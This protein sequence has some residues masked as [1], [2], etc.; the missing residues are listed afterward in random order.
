MT[1]SKPYQKVVDYFQALESKIG[2][3]LVLG[4]VKHFGYY[5]SEKAKIS[6]KKA[7]ELMQDLIAKKLKLTKDDKV[8][9][10]G[11]GQGN[12][13]CYLTTK[14]SCSVTGI[15]ITPFEVDKAQ[16]LAQK[17]KVSDKVKFLKMD[18]TKTNFPDNYFDAIY[19]MESFVHAYDVKKSLKEF[20]R[21]LKSKGKIVFF[22]YSIPDDKK[23]REFDKKERLGFEKL[24]KWVI[25]K[26]AMFNLKKLRYGVFPKILN[27][28]GFVDISE[29]NITNH[30]K[31]SLLRLYCLATIP[32][33]IVKL[34]QLR[35]FFFNTTVAGEWFKVLLEYEDADLFRYN[36]TSAQKP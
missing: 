25:E 36:I 6:E 4:G 28:I 27:E 8:L 5:P 26:G 9:D 7:Q 12:V 34:F 31:P 16:K 35:E 29:V 13:A 22:E 2:Y 1:T 23:I 33:Q 14:H 18:Y 10:A 20:K 32:Y 21:I 15:T 11:C 30:V 19:T 24:T 17:L 3:D